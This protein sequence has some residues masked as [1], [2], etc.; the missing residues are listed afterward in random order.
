[1]LIFLG[2][3]FIVVSETL[4]MPIIVKRKLYLIFYRSFRIKKLS[5]LRTKH[6]YELVWII[7]IRNHSLYLV[8][9]DEYDDSQFS[10][11]SPVNTQ[12][13]L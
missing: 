12:I 1:M 11:T 6:I 10:F 3:I 9:K 13:E 2:R 4:D 8:C 5:Y 7:V